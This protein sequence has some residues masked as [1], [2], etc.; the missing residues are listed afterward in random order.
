[1]RLVLF[2]CDGTLVDS[3]AV[4]HDC[5]VRTF[6]D[7]ERV[8]PDLP[9]TKSVIG[10]SLPIAIDRL[11]GAGTEAELAALT[12]RYR[13]HF[14][15]LR[16]RDTVHEPMFDGIAALIAE[17]TR[18][19]TVLLGVVTGKSRRGL[20][21]V[22]KR[23]ELETAF[24]TVRTA[25]DCPS[26][27]HPAMVLECCAEAGIDP[28]DTIVVG[29]AVYDMQMAKAAG[30]TAIGVSWGYT[31]P[32]GLSGAGADVI[33]DMPEHLFDHINPRAVMEA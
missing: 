19:E 26:K 33:I 12:A 8:V 20:A 21:A 29:D 25:D 7:F 1:M 14:T 24:F 2:D 9:A 17:L 31:S 5:M 22:L 27:P 28:S 11:R 18:R 4:I 3:A 15:D 16:A 23:H 6:A 10:L 30:A 32:E 13:S